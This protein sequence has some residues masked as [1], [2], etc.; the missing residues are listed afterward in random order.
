QLLFLAATIAV[1]AF[2]IGTAIFCWLSPIP[3]RKWL[4]RIFVLLAFGTLSL[5]WTTGEIRY[6][7]VYLLLLGAG[8]SKPF[9]G[10][11]LLN[12]GLPVGALLFWWQRRAWLKQKAG[13]A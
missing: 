8:F 1:G 10:P 12:I 4:W 6:Q 2:T 3:R 11:A 7:L 9:Y 13:E 5:N